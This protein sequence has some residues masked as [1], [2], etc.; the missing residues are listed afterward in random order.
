MKKEEATLFDAAAKESSSLTDDDSS[1]FDSQEM[2][3]RQL[4]RARQ[5]YL[6]VL[7]RNR[8]LQPSL[9]V[10][11]FDI[12]VTEVTRKLVEQQNHESIEAETHRILN[13]WA[14]AHGMDRRMAGTRAG[15]HERAVQQIASRRLFVMVCHADPYIQ[16]PRAVSHAGDFSRIL[17]SI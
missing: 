7:S 8:D 3:R 12:E 6:D 16:W 17:G 9:L 1:L 4:M 10:Q 2:R 5:D 15:V 11:S 14:A 13:A